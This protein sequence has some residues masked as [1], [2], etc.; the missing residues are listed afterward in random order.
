MTPFKI[1]LTKVTVC[2]G[3]GRKKT[4]LLR[5]F[6]RVMELLKGYWCKGWWRVRMSQDTLLTVEA[7][8]CRRYRGVPS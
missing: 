6:L 7:S 1:K 4:D 5:R 8:E 3:L 2:K